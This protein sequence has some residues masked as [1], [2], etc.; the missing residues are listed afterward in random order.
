MDRKISNLLFDRRDYM[1]LNIVNDVLTRDESRKHTKK[2]I[3]PYLHPH[4]IKEMA[5]SRGLRIAHAVVHLLEYLEAEGIDD[6]LNALRSIRDEL[7]DTAEGSMPKN[8]ARVLMQIMKELVRAHGNHILQLK[9]AHDFRACTTG[10]PGVVRKQMKNYHLLEMPEEWNQVTFDDHVHDANTKG[11]K[12]SSHL[13]MDAWIKGIRRLKVVYYNYIE[14][15]FAVE[16]MEAARIMGIDI[17]IGI[18][19]NARFRNRYIQMIW[20]PKGFAD[21]Q[22][23]L[24]FL[25]EEPV[26]AIMDEGKKVSEY[27][28][29]IVLS[30]L[31]EFNERHRF[32]I[33]K[34]YGFLPPLLDE[35]AFLSFVGTGQASLF[36]LAKF[37]H[38]GI[39]AA[40][41]SY[42]DELKRIYP[43]ASDEEQRIMENKVDA[44]NQIDHEK[45]LDEYLIHEKNPH[46]PNP[47]I[48]GG[49]AE[50]P[51]LLTLSP[52]TLIERLRKLR[53]SCRITLNLSNLKAE[54]VLEILYDCEGY[55]TCLEIFNL[56]DYTL[57]LTGHISE[58]NELQK[59]LNQGNVIELKR[60]IKNMIFR[61]EASDYPDR[62]NRAARLN[63]IL[64]DISIFKDYYKRVP[65]KSRIGS[66]ST[67]RSPRFHGMGLAVIET[68]PRLAQK[69]IRKHSGLSYEIIPGKIAV[70]RRII[71]I[72]HT[73][74][75]AVAG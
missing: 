56:K 22:D 61:I 36:H 14:P 2:T 9:L 75:W 46:I 60:I 15:K 64:H 66:D 69:E 73:V 3:Y 39:L 16:L 65:L 47:R 54:D 30:I 34:R 21:T 72:P 32:E 8:T 49:S 17:D 38:S 7:L 58:I 13:I 11:R 19:F 24:I 1:L 70:F 31:K 44:M 4:G 26:R 62:E 52:L 51:Y 6:R 57:G 59:A 55:V 20:T 43:N 50:L 48:P 28:G 35:K 12:S 67:G 5:E 25:E 18:E 33:Q 74:S 40:M 41:N 53:S 63:D 37:A 23:F 45:I 29:R 68:L 10:K 42:T 27:Q 71:Y